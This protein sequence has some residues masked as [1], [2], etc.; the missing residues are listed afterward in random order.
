MRLPISVPMNPSTIIAS[1][2]MST[3]ATPPPL[4]FPEPRTRGA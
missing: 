4:F 1:A 2:M 3:I